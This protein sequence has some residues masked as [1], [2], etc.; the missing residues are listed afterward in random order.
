MLDIPNPTSAAKNRSK[1]CLMQQDLII[2]QSQMTLGKKKINLFY[3]NPHFP[4][5]NKLWFFYKLMRSLFCRPTLCRLTGEQNKEMSVRSQSACLAMKQ[6][7]N[8]RQCTPM[9]CQVSH[10]DSSVFNVSLSKTA[11]QYFTWLYNTIVLCILRSKD[12][13]PNFLDGWFLVRFLTQ[14]TG[15]NTLMI[16]DKLWKPI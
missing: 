1:D 5:N 6:N 9:P 2:S 8:Q 10:T 11:Y 16:K 13:F 7:R 15:K 4:L 14:P 3:F 12:T